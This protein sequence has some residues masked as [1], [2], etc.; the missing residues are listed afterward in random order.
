MDK[1]RSSRISNLAGSGNTPV[2]T[3]TLINTTTN[4]IDVVYIITPNVNGCNGTPFNLTITV[5]PT[6]RSRSAASEVVCNGDNTTAV[7][8]TT[9]NTGGVTTYTWTNDNITIG[10]AAS[11]NGDIPSFTAINNGTAPEVATIVVTPH[12]SN[13]GKMCDGPTKTF[14][15]TV[16]PTGRSRSAGQRG[17]LQR[18]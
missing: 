7:N 17:C 16:N 2:I 11:G 5:N 13:G 3:E 10:L 6:G 8:F 1:S 12:F 15:I 14:T 9:I 4:P 18:R